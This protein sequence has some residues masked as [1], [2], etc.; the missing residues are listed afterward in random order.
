MR[1]A[2]SRNTLTLTTFYLTRASRWLSGGSGTARSCRARRGRGPR[3]TLGA[4]PLPP[5]V[6]APRSPQLRGQGEGRP[7]AGK[8]TRGCS[9]LCRQTQRTGERVK[10][11]EEE[12]SA[13]FRRSEGGLAETRTRPPQPPSPEPL[14]PKVPARSLPVAHSS[15]RLRAL[16]QRCDEWMDRERQTPRVRKR[17]RERKIETYPAGTACT[18]WG[19]PRAQK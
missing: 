15:V 9:V 17:R 18:R 8:R 7:G 6:S 5:A 11:R 16:Q 3:S 14:L 4:A 1:N 13:L 2:P 12:R 10:E 19:P